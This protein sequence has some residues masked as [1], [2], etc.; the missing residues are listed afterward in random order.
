MNN[1]TKTIQPV[2]EIRDDATGCTRWLQKRHLKPTV[3]RRTRRP[4]SSRNS[5][6]NLHFRA[7]LSI[8]SR[9]KGQGHRSG[10][11][12]GSTTTGTCDAS[13]FTGGKLIG[14]VLTLLLP[15]PSNGDDTCVCD[16]TGLSATWGT[17]GGAALGALSSRSVFVLGI[18]IGFRHW[19]HGPVFPAFRSGAFRIAPQWG[20]ATRMDSSPSTVLFAG[21]GC[22]IIGR[23]GTCNRCPQ[24]EQS[25]FTPAAPSGDE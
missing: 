12:A 15:R 5:P 23:M 3:S 14:A 25:N 6:Q 20:Q 4:R 1:I 13:T 24:F 22:G 10:L 16:S 7:K 19:G 11:S 9:Q 17:S 8:S 2:C 18:V 21:F